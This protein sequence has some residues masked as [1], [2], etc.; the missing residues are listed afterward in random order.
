MKHPYGA[1]TETGDPLCHAHR[2]T[3]CHHCERLFP[4]LE[5]KRHVVGQHADRAPREGKPPPLEPVFGYFCSSCESG[6][7]SSPAPEFDGH[8]MVVLGLA[9]LVTA[10]ML[11]AFMLR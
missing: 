1:F 10:V 4:H 8:R 9:L 5:M 6:A 7:T 3:R 11:A 2:L